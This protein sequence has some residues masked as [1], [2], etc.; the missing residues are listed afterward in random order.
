MTFGLYLEASRSQIGNKDVV[1]WTEG[2][3]LNQKC[4]WLGAVC[5]T[6]AFNAR[7]KTLEPVGVC[8]VYGIVQVHTKMSI[9]SQLTSYT[10]VNTFYSPISINTLTPL[11]HKLVFLSYAPNGIH[12]FILPTQE[13]IIFRL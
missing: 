3:A 10:P 12:S 6:N 13:D 2:S 9:F 11:G 8:N 1:K 4:I 7:R 5:K